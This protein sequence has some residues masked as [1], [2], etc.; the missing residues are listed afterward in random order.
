MKSTRST[1]SAEIETRSLRF[2]CGFAHIIKREKA[3]MYF[4]FNWLNCLTS[5]NVSTTLTFEL[6]VKMVIPRVKS[7]RV[8]T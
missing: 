8:I 7:V 1:A 4:Y 6:K 3:E 5:Y 2:R